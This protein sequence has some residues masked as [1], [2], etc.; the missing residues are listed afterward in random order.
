MHHHARDREPWALWREGLK[1]EMGVRDYT[2]KIQK[3][4]IVL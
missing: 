1:E 4:Y 2:F 3:G